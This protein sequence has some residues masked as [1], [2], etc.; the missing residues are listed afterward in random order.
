MQ[1]LKGVGPK[2][3]E[4]LRDK[5]L[6]TVEDLLFYPPF[7]YE[8]RTRFTPLGSLRAGDSGAV[9]ATVAATRTKTWGK[10][11]RPLFEAELVDETGKRML[12]RWYQARYLANEIVPGLRMALFGKAEFDFQSSRVFLAH[13]EFEV[14]PEATF[15]GAMDPEAAL[16]MGCI[17]PIYEAIGKISRK[18]LR[19]FTLRALEAAGELRDAL[20]PAVLERFKLPRLGE[21]IRE[22][23]DP[24]RESSVEALN[25]RRSPGHWR[26]IFEEFFWLEFGLL[27]KRA[28]V[29]RAEGIAFALTP[30][31]RER[32]KQMLPFRPTAAQYRA[33]GEIS[34][35]MA[36]P[37]PM[38]RLLQ[39]DVG[40]GKTLVAA[41]ATV[42]AVENGYQVAF[43]APTEILAAQHYVSLQRFYR[44][45]GY[46]VGLVVGSQ[47]AREK[48]Q[49]KKLAAEGHL[50]ILVGTH[51]LLEKD[52]EFARLGLAIIDEQHRFGVMQRLSLRKKGPAPDVL[53]M[54]ATPIPRTLA[55]TIYGDLDVSIID[56]MPPGRKPIVTRQHGQAKSKTVYEEVREQL[57]AGRQAYIVYPLV[58]DS[59]HA[60][61]LKSAM[62]MH[63]LHA[64]KT[65]PGFRVGLLHGQLP[66]A[67]KEAVMRSFKEHELDVLVATTVVEVGLDVP[68]ATVMVIE[69]A[70][71][72]GL[73]QLHQLRGRVGRGQHAS[74]CF[75]LSG[76]LNETSQQRLQALVDSGDGFRLAEIDLEIR[77]PGE[78]FGTKQ[79]GL[80][81]LRF[82]Q[83]IED[84]EILEIARSEAKR[85][86]E[87]PVH[88][89]EQAAAIEYLRE[90]WQR[91]Y[92]LVQVA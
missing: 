12:A 68:N 92:G 90:H 82:A 36:R 89:G 21:A 39:G 2:L 33:L 7:R 47:T 84:R 35:D 3:G 44:P 15:S 70:E 45:L 57:A 52:V 71:K 81:T 59:E 29:R 86:L 32:V 28:Q 13:P 61:D 42:I 50:Q 78:F 91:R 76:K 73:A 66:A 51:A 1:Y 31:I 53:V 63:E 54:T 60:P 55:L 40:S 19:R 75:L 69:N 10:A 67:E 49:I 25:A 43:L 16:S 11:A 87:D 83:V 64:E 5:G 88:A 80:P 4:V 17:V 30:Q 72:F 62:K 20:P 41:E 34:A 26:L 23:H 8:D 38:N 27:R 22:I 18:Q 9:L 56:A 65:F 48:S 14:L 37:H 79:S 6:E 85:F 77:G 74:Y 58:D 46:S 24:G